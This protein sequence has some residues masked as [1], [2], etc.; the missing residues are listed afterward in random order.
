MIR[1]LQTR[2]VVAIACTVEFDRI[3]AAIYL[4]ED[5][6]GERSLVDLDTGN[7]YLVTLPEEIETPAYH[8]TL[9]RLPSKP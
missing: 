2:G 8:V 7:R 3:I 1:L 6:I 4:A 9:C 5:E